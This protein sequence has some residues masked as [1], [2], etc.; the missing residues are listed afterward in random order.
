MQI[1]TITDAPTYGFTVNEIDDLVVFAS[2]EAIRTAS[3]FGEVEPVW[4][5]Q[6]DLP[7]HR[8]ALGAWLSERRHLWDEWGRLAET[9]GAEALDDRI[10]ALM[11]AAPPAEPAE[12]LMR[13]GADARELQIDIVF[14][15]GPAAP[16]VT[17]ALQSG[18]ARTRFVRQ[19]GGNA[20]V[21][22]LWEVVE[23]GWFLGTRFLHAYLDALARLP[24]PT[25][26]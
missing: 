18:R 15:R 7:I 26:R 16:V 10:C 4:S 14:G 12:I 3:P 23:A 21:W 24:K 11:R 5:Y 13:R 8:Y 2:T 25:R 1:N 22:D 20:S 19:F 6:F 17:H 9:E